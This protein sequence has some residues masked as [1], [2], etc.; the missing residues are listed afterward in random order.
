MAGCSDAGPAANP[1]TSLYS[2]DVIKVSLDAP[3]NAAIVAHPRLFT[4]SRTGAI[5]GLWKK[6]DHGP[7][8]Q[9]TFTTDMCHDITAFPELG[10]AAGACAGNGLLLDISDPMKPARHRCRH[11]SELH[12]LAHGNFQQ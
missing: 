6:G 2:I 8:S 1:E 5:D 11:R 10:L 9:K 7:G 3:Q 12:L 4:D